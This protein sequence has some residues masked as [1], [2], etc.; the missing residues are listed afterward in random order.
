MHSKL[1]AGVSFKID[2]FDYLFDG[3]AVRLQQLIFTARLNGY[4]YT[5]IVVNLHPY[6]DRSRKNELLEA[7][8]KTVKR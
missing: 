3:L 7:N 1:E 4:R 2:I 6:R 5:L 8:G